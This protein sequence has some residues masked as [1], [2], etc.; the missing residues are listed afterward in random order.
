MSYYE[1]DCCEELDN[2]YY[3]CK[4]T[5]VSISNFVFCPYCGTRL[6]EPYEPTSEESKLLRDQTGASIV[7][8]KAA[9]MWSNG[10]MEQ[11]KE[12]IREIGIVKC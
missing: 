4:P 7:T 9:L 1:L 11:A 2:L 10:D 6:V 5:S 8:C 12:R 3:E